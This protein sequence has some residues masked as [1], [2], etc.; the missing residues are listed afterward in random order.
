MTQMFF[1]T[2]PFHDYSL[3]QIVQCIIRGQRPGQLQSPEMGPNTWNLIQK[4]WESIPS[5]RP[6]M[7]EIVEVLTLQLGACL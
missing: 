1:N 2:I 7:K 3:A 4:C 5:E 6:K